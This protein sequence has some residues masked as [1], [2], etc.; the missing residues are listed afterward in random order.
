MAISLQST[1]EGEEASV[2]GWVGHKLLDL[3]IKLKKKNLVTLI[4]M[5]GSLLGMKSISG[6]NRE[7]V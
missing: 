5:A 7:Q 4:T 1:E 6:S 2:R 3:P